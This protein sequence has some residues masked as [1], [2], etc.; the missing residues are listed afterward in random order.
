MSSV[1][2][3]L[4]EYDGYLTEYYETGMESLGLILQDKRGTSPNPNYDPKS[5]TYPTN[6][7]QW[8]SLEYS[9]FFRGTEFIEVYRKDGSIE[10]RG[11]ITKDRQAMAKANYSMFLP[12]EVPPQ[13][14]LSWFQ[15]GRKAKA[16]SHTPPYAVKIEQERAKLALL[17]PG[18][19]V[20]INPLIPNIGPAKFGWVADTNRRSGLITVHAAEMN[21]ET[22]HFSPGELVDINPEFLEPIEE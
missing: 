7:P 2:K 12:K 13:T 14:W 1:K 11:S 15:E 22:G 10:Y 8:C 19:R 20:R 3:E 18:R 16:W 21:I 17:T 9:L 4:Y 5:T 6:I